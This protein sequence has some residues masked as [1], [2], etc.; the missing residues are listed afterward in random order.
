MLRC[1]GTLSFVSLVNRR[2]PRGPRWEFD[3]EA[4]YSD[5]QKH[6][7]QISLAEGLVALGQN[8]PAGQHAPGVQKLL[9]WSALTD[10]VSPS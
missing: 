1:G 10:L 5:L 7:Y 8:A 6:A 4:N 3:T 9:K 2:M